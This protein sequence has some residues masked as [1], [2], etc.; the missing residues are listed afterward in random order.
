MDLTEARRVLAAAAAVESKVME[1]FAGK[2]Y[3]QKTRA[4]LSAMRGNPAVGAEVA[5][6]DIAPARLCEMTPE[7]LA[8]KEHWRHETAE[9]VERRRHAEADIEV[10]AAEEAAAA[11]NTF[12]AKDHR[13][14]WRDH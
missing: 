12:I 1:K 2:A 3:A 8:P 5:R 14:R 13:E 7:E 9:R 10:H 6:G 11:R 4:L